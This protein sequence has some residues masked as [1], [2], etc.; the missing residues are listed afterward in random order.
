MPLNKEGKTN[1]IKFKYSFPFQKL[2]L[3][4]QFYINVWFL[5]KTYSQCDHRYF[6]LRPKD[7]I[8]RLYVSKIKKNKT[9]RGSGFIN[10]EDSIDASNKNSKKKTAMKCYIARYGYAKWIYNVHI[11]IYRHR[12]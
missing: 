8:D 6:R 4:M 7:D 9:K 11:Y 3:Y 1:Q 5:E 2:G 12:T 10:I